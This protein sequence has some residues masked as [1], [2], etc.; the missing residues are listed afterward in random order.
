[1]HVEGHKIGFLNYKMRCKDIRE[2]NKSIIII[3]N[4]KDTRTRG[5]LLFF[6]T[7]YNFYTD[8]IAG[9]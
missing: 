7:F 6:N 9:E 1:M 2:R 8:I 5:P 4:N 3:N